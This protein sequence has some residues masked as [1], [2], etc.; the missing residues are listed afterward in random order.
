MFNSQNSHGKLGGEDPTLQSL[1]H[2]HC[3]MSA[4]TY[5]IINKTNFK[6]KLFIYAKPICAP[7]MN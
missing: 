3:G 5:R 1:P 2:A 6:D 7:I 4:Q